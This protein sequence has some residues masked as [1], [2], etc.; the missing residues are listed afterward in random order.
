[1]LRAGGRNIAYHL[2]YIGYL[3]ERRNWLGGDHLS[4][5][6]LAA[7]AQLSCL[8]YMGDV[9]WETAHAAKLWYARLK[10]RPS[11]QPLFADRVPG[12]TPPRHYA[13]PDF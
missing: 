8:D 12:V 10:S 13:D 6:D 1:V 5:A 3:T 2:D 11:F 4:L 7:A 9:P